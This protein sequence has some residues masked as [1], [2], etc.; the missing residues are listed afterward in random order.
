MTGLFKVITA[1]LALL[2]VGCGTLTKAYDIECASPGLP[3]KFVYKGFLHGKMAGT[4]LVLTTY[5]GKVYYN[6]PSGTACQ[7]TYNREEE[8][9]PSRHQL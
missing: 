6:L 1:L 8:Y 2:F 3:E 7:I 4:V 9:E 5:S